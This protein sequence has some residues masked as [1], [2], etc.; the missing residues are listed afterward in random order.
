MQLRSLCGQKS[1]PGS[2]AIPTMKIDAA[3]RLLPFSCEQV[4]D[5]AADVE[6]YPEYMPGWI[7]AKILK[8]EADVLYVEQVVGMGPVHVKFRS[9]AVL[10]RPRQIDVTSSEAPFRHYRLTWLLVP[11]PALSCAL[12]LTIELE[13][14][15]LALQLVVNRVLPA[16]VEGVI[17]AFQSRANS[18][19]ARGDD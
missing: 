18:L 17:G 11:H 6:R 1:Y 12:S 5:L 15:S 3:S 8:K 16:S 4:F 14:E 13:L 7:S 10:H 19:Y 2:W 9:K